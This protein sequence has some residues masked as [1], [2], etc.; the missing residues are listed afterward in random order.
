MEQDHRGVKRI[1]NA[2]LGFDE[3]RRQEAEGTKAFSSPHVGS[4]SG[5]FR[6]ATNRK[7]L[8]FGLA[9]VLNPKARACN[10][11]AQPITQP[12]ASC[13]LPSAFGAQRDKSFHTAC[14]TIRGIEIMHMINKG[15]VEGVS[16]K[17]VLGQK[18][19]VESL[20]GIAV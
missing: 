4:I 10:R 13:P 9:G 7:P 6:L 17:D 18:K 11:A 20:F 3:G 14:R 2:G 1:T 16:T 8:T 19:F 12:S 15:Q 5:R